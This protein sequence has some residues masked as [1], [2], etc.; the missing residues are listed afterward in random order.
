MPIAAFIS[1]SHA[2]D[3]VTPGRPATAIR[4]GLGIQPARWAAV[5][6]LLAVLLAVVWLGQTLA[7]RYQVGQ[8]SSRANQDAAAHLASQLS[9][10]Q[11]SRPFVQARLVSRT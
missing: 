6:V 4:P 10:D 8:Q 1:I 3:A 11:P 7:L 5:A 9:V 2:P